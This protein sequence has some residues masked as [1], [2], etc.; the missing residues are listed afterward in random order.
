MGIS[1]LSFIMPEMAAC[2]NLHT[3]HE[4]QAY[5]SRKHTYTD[6]ISYR[7]LNNRQ[8]LLSQLLF[9]RWNIHS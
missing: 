4:I 3:E 5:S 2:K 1:S 7:D 9:A 8:S 6:Y